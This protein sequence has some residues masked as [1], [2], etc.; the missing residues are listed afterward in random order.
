MLINYMA[1]LT[2]N[3]DDRDLS[4]LTKHRQLAS[5][6]FAGR[7][8]L[9]D[10][11]LSN[12]VNS[13]VKRIGILTQNKSASL[14]RHLN[15][16][17]PWDLDRKI[18]GLTILNFDNKNEYFKD[19]EMTKELVRFILDSQHK[20]VIISPSYM[21]C[22][23]N[24]EK[25]AEY[26]EQSNADITV[27]YKTIEDGNKNFIGC[28]TLNLDGNNNILGFGKNIG[29][30]HK[31][32]LSTEIFIMDKKVLINLIYQALEK[33]AFSSI[34]EAVQKNVGILRINGFEFKGYL[35]CINSVRAYYD[36][37]REMLNSEIT[38]ELFFKNGLIYTKVKDEAPTKYTSNSE[39]KNSLIANGCVIDGKVES[40]IIGRRVVIQKGCEIKNCVIMQNCTIKDNVKL[41]NIIICKDMIIE[42]NK[43]LRA[44]I[45]Y[46]LIIEKEN[47]FNIPK[48]MLKG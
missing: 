32:N 6:P 40:S 27:V 25:A 22:N 43:Q 16:G 4:S 17:K 3:E 29:M 30:S 19:I 2:L 36:A 13:G 46:P 48:Y 37:N 45:D 24:L 9:I 11:M 35:R 7:Y 20:Y 18:N 31:H 15:A 1:I 42:A 14:T 5:I 12:L 23:I 10:F 41:S 8:R 28:D 34:R 21:L 44:E 39:V 47:A 26:H 33:G 38:N